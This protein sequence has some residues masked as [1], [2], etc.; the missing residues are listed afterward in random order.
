MKAQFEVSAPV[1]RD[2]FAN[3]VVVAKDASM[4][5]PKDLTPEMI[6]QLWPEPRLPI[7]P[8]AEGIKVA[9]H[10]R[11]AVEAKYQE[12]MAAY[13]AE[14]QER[15]A[16]IERELP[17]VN[18]SRGAARVLTVPRL[19][20]T[21]DVKDG[22]ARLY[23]YGFS[24]YMAGRTWVPIQGG[25]DLPPV[26]VSIPLEPAKSIPT[27]L[28]TIPGG[29]K[30]MVEVTMFDEPQRVTTIGEDGQQ[31]V[32]DLSFAIRH[33]GEPRVEL[34]ED[35]PAGESDRWWD[36]LD[37][38]IASGDATVRAP[39]VLSGDTMDRL[40]K[41][42][43]IGGELDIVASSHDHVNVVRRGTNFEG[44]IGAVNRDLYVRGIEKE[45][46]E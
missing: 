32:I 2:A 12:S 7:H 17:S 9:P 42:K 40:G 33:D 3:A 8:D 5:K 45:G 34:V 26:S 38:L 46:S 10:M 25:A 27:M 18:A 35:D 36:M 37:E 14:M 28:R 1:L 39:L 13:N 4:P 24:R 19:L 30:G 43:T 20:L 15:A 11:Q 29:M 22:D 41:L 31:Q 21:L 16:R 23:V 44:I 6:K